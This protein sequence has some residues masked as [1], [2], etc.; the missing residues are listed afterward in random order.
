MGSLLHDGKRDNPSGDAGLSICCA[1]D[2]ARIV[3][4]ADARAYRVSIGDARE[5]LI[6][7][8]RC[9]VPSLIGKLANKT[10]IVTKRRSA[11]RIGRSKRIMREF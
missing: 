9:A 8:R 5:G 7:M 11:Y 1:S 6:N 3:L 4:A 2:G 10:K